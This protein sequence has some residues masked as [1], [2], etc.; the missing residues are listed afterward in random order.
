[1]ADWESSLHM[2]ALPTN[3]YISFSARFIFCLVCPSE[4]RFEVFDTPCQQL[5]QGEGGERRQQAGDPTPASG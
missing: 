2:H 4:C 5:T 3:K 1:M